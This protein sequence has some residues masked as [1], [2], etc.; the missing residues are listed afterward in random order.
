MMPL[1]TLPRPQSKGVRATRSS[2]F[3]YP[4]VSVVAHDQRP[5]LPPHGRGSLIPRNTKKKEGEREPAVK[6]RFTLSRSN[7]TVSLISIKEPPVVSPSNRRKVRAIASC[8]AGGAVFA[9]VTAPSLR[10]DIRMGSEQTGSGT[11]PISASRKSMVDDA[12]IGT[13]D[14]T[15]RQSIPA[16]PMTFLEGGG[17][18]KGLYAFSWRQVVSFAGSESLVPATF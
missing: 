14:R 10:G 7:E 11:L 4:T 13:V 12:T 5:L 8:L 6:L 15:S 17:T 16:A 2:R 9:L 3:R 1:R 18:C